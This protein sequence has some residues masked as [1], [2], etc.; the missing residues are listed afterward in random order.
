MYEIF[1]TL[2]QKNGV[3]SYKVSKE[4]G[5]SQSTLSDWKRGLSTPKLDKLQKIA[6]YFGVTVNY[7]MT[8]EDSIESPK[9]ALTPKDERD[10]AKDLEN[11]MN[12][13][14][15]KEA[16]PASFDGQELSD[17][18]AELFREELEIALKRLKLINKEK[19][20]P[21]KNKK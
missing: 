19:Y 3:T 2:L 17:E 21:K 12:K 15:N 1:S 14:S 9:A 7:L 10:I 4:T 11:I 18:S 13:L 16:G 5:V 6:D 20:N 8:G